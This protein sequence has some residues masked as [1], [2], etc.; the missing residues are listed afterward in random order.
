MRYP[1]LS[2]SVLT[3]ALCI[4]GAM[5]CGYHPGLSNAPFD[6]AHPQS[7]SVALAVRQATDSGVLEPWSTSSLFGAEYRSA[8]KQLR[9]LQKKLARVPSSA[10]GGESRHFA[11]VFVRS[12]LWAQYMVGPNGTK[13]VIHTA[14][15]RDGEVVLLSDEAVLEAVINDRLAFDDAVKQGLLKFANDQDG[16]TFEMVRAAFG[17]EEL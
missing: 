15:A 6:V 3:I 7:L 16:K 9:S 2:L 4:R 12:R 14:A 5:A 8:V 1:A 10:K 17:S 13:A 11:F